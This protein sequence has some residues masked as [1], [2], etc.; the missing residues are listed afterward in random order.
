MKILEVFMWRF[1][2]GN[3]VALLGKART[4]QYWTLSIL[5]IPGFS[6]VAVSLEPYTRG[7]Q[8]STVLCP[9]QSPSKSLWYEPRWSEPARSYGSAAGSLECERHP[10]ML[11]Y[12]LDL[13]CPPKAHVLNKGLVSNF[14]V[15]EPLR[16]GASWEVVLLEPI[17]GVPLKGIMG[18]FLFLFHSWSWDEQNSSAM[19]CRQDVLPCTGPKAMASPIIDWNFQNYEPK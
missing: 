18:S 6:S 5:S 13:N 12:S 19:G 4:V 2:R 10:Q 14:E 17:G 7:H 8:G 11:W 15:V 9:W 1:F 3:W 16:G